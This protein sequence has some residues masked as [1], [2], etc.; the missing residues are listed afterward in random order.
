MQNIKPKRSI[1]WKLAAAF[2]AVAGFVA[3]FVGVVIT[4]HFETVEHAV[5]LS[6]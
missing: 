5:Q 3:A 4:I 2:I 6:S 1:R